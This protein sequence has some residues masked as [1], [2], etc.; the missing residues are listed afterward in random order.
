MQSMF[1]YL[2]VF[3]CAAFICVS[4]NTTEEVKPEAQTPTT[5]KNQ[6]LTNNCPVIASSFA[7]R[8]V[9]VGNTLTQ[10]IRRNETKNVIKTFH[11]KLA[12]PHNYSRLRLEVKAFDGGECNGIGN[13]ANCSRM[14]IKDAMGRV[15]YETTLPGVKFITVPGTTFSITLEKVCT[16]RSSFLTSKIKIDQGLYAEI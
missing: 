6:R 9:Y 5:Q 2:V 12:Q 14:I 11:Y 3:V 7:P 8:N 10:T 4:C 15:V 13:P 1:K 16:N